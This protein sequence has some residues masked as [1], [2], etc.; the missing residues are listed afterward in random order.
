MFDLEKWTRDR[1]R[2]GSL[3]DVA[4]RMYQANLTLTDAATRLKNCYALEALMA[5]EGIQTKAAE[6]LGCH[7]N[8]L[9]QMVR[10]L[11]TTTQ[12]IRLVAK[13]LKALR[14]RM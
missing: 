10:R 14:E 6:S 4:R 13:A 5:N 1:H 7:R 3:A 8:Q 12:H 2:T 11:G 9:R